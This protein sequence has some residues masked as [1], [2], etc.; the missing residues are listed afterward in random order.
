MRTIA[1]DLNVSHTIINKKS[2]S[3]VGKYFFVN[4]KIKKLFKKKQN[5]QK[6]NR[7]QGL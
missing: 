3:D 6:N 5:T 4:T 7:P 2:W 1:K